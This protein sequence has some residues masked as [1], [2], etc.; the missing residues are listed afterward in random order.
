MVAAEG[1]AAELKAR[2]GETTV[3]LTFADAHSTRRA[4]D[5][6]ADFDASTLTNDVHALAIPLRGG[7]STV[8]TVLNLLDSASIV[9]EHIDLHEPTL[10]EV[11]L[12]LTGTT[13]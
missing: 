5:L 13:A 10:D 6:L 7:P 9:A 8:R 11:F 12:S 1:T 3:V 2:L 4:A